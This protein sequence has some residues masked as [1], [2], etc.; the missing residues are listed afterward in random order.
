[1]NG[2]GRNLKHLVSIALMNR[3][4]ILRI[5][6]RAIEMMEYQYANRKYDLFAEDRKKNPDFMAP[7]ASA[8]MLQKSTGT[9]TSF[10]WAFMRLCFLLMNIES[11]DVLSRGK[12]EPFSHSL[13]RMLTSAGT[14]MVAIRSA[15]EGMCLALALDFDRAHGGHTMLHNRIS[16][17]NAGEGESYHTTQILLD[18]LT[19]VVWKLL[20]EDIR[21]DYP[22][23][24]HQNLVKALKKFSN[25]SPEERKRQIAAAI[26]GTMICFGGDLKSRIFYDYLSLARGD[27]HTRKFD[28]TFV[29][30]CPEFARP[31]DRYLQG[32]SHYVVDEF[33]PHMMV[34]NRR[35]DFFYRLRWRLEDRPKELHE[36]INRLDEDFRVRVPFMDVLLANGA[37]F[38]EALPVDKKRPSI[39]AEAIDHPNCLCWLQNSCGL[40]VRMAVGAEAYECWKTDELAVANAW[41]VPDAVPTKLNLMEQMSLSEYRNTRGKSKF[42]G[43]DEVNVSS[44][45]LLDHLPVDSSGFIKRLIRSRNLYQGGLLPK[46]RVSPRDSSRQ[47]E[48]K[49]ML[50]VPGISLKDFLKLDPQILT[51]ID[52]LTDKN[53]SVVEFNPVEDI[54]SKSTCDVEAMVVGIFDCPRGINAEGEDPECAMGHKD[55]FVYPTPITSLQ[56]DRATCAYCGKIHKPSEMRKALERSLPII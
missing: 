35:P 23:T 55:E 15:Y 41:S 51:V 3:D 31:D 33:D 22:G 7:A 49:D 16:L 32:V 54:F 53:I 13:R 46:D 43:A 42:S 25:L 6:D 40:A 28:I 48:I 2:L 21:K 1:M 9:R 17:I 18:L 30:A 38:L 52:F 19:M 37:Y 36:L 56:H 45:F 8:I 20:G 39:V 50:W 26:D 14:Q 47:N 44:G 10:I 11:P 29:L 5:L 12:G 24:G 27:E 4:Q 34:N